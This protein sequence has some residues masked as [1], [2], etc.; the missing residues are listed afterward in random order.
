MSRNVP[1]QTPQ[2][3]LQHL[4]PVASAIPP[5]ASHASTRLCTA[6]RSASIESM[7]GGLPQVT[8]AEARLSPQQASAPPSLLKQ[9]SPPQTPHEAGQHATPKG[10]TTPPNCMHA[11]ILEDDIILESC[12]CVP[13]S[14]AAIVTATLSEASRGLCVIQGGSTNLPKPKGAP[15]KDTPSK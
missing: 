3:A 9:P 11:S 7:Q 12:P 15:Q 2:D 4:K 10:S 8:L 1:P 6:S 5:A 13:V 14:E